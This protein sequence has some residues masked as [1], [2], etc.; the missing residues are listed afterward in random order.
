MLA[1]KIQE[2]GLE[3]DLTKYVEHAKQPVFAVVVH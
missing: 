1:S 2:D 3:P